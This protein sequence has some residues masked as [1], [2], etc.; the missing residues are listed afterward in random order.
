MFKLAGHAG[1][2]TCESSRRASEIRIP[3]RVLF[4]DPSSSSSRQTDFDD[5]VRL[6]EDVSLK[7]VALLLRASVGEIWQ[8]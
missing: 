7:A 8:R 2:V 5:L 4:D 3:N 1:N 6:P